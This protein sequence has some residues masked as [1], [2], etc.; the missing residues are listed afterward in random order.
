MAIARF[1]VCMVAMMSGAVLAAPFIVSDPL[2]PRATHCGWQFNSD[3]RVD[4]PV[5]L[6]GT[7]KI[8]KVDLAGRAVGSYTVTATAV[9]IDP[10][11]GRLESASSAPFV[12]AV[13][14]VAGAPSNLRLVP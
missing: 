3:A 10:S 7:D 6:S 12:F 11:W 2:D 9:A 14:S 1:L 4:A 8:C 5:A 13:P